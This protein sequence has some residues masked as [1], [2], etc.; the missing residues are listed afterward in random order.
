MLILNKSWFPIKVKDIKDVIGKLC[1]GNAKI[2]DED[3]IQY[4][5]QEWLDK[6][7][8]PHEQEKNI[9]YEF[10]RAKNFSVKSPKVMICTKY[11][12]VPNIS[13]KLTRRNILI[14][15][16]FACQYCEQKLSMR[17]STLDHIIPRS[18]GGKNS[19]ENLVICCISCNTIKS[20]KTLEETKF[21]LSH[22]PEK[23]KWSPIYSIMVKKW[24]KIWDK[25]I[26]TDKWNKF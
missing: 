22:K 20:D 8:I 2:I 1:N 18:R 13:L 19:W 5:W 10:I 24:P 12:K 16:S 23:P 21:K 11:N 6:Y 3:F 4:S 25:F 7:S 26:N 17:N 15:D 14:R 9:K